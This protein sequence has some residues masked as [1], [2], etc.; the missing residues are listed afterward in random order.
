MQD[1]KI[2]VNFINLQK[3]ES[4]EIYFGTHTINGS[5]EKNAEDLMDTMHLW[6]NW[7]KSEIELLPIIKLH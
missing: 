4:Y 5:T 7:H 2:F 3:E 6:T 1:H